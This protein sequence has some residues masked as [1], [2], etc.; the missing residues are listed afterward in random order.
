M[1]G[2]NEI[3]REGEIDFAKPLPRA[4]LRD[5]RLS[6]GAR[7]LFAFLWDLPNGWSPCLEHLVKMTPEGRDAIRARLGELQRVGA[8]RIEAKREDK[9]G[10]TLPRGQISGRRWVLASPA[11]WAIEAP[12]SVK[13]KIQLSESP[14]VGESPTKVLQGSKVLQEEA[15][16]PRA[17]ARGPA[18]A[19][20]L[21]GKRNSPRR[22]KNGIECWYPSEDPEA[23]AIE[24]SVPPE[25]IARAVAAIRARPN[26]AGKPTSPF[27]G[28]VAAEIERQRQLNVAHAAEQERIAQ[29]EQDRQIAE[30]QSAMRT[31]KTAQAEAYFD[32]LSDADRGLLINQFA[33]HLAAINDGV[34]QLYRKNNLHSKSVRFELFKF[35]DTTILSTEEATV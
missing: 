8:V 11:R 21:S 29:Q 28:L 24:D 27:P 13:G 5:S 7:G 10:N 20:A 12:L 4:L 9:D 23:D 15:A 26:S 30:Q 32:S 22:T 3:V 19:A 2:K 35:I 6:F 14:I 1:S 31:A 34:Y 18:D 16:A 33:T 25:Q 17:H